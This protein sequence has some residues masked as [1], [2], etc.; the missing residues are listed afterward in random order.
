[1]LDRRFLTLLRVASLSMGICVEAFG[2]LIA[3][4]ILGTIIGVVSFHFVCISLAFI[5]QAR[6]E[7][8]CMGVLWVFLP[9]YCPERLSFACWLL[10]CPVPTYVVPLVPRPVSPV[11]PLVSPLTLRAAPC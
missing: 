9:F 7:R 1:M 10:P 6:G 11:S 2:P 3:G 8:R 5:Y 4:I